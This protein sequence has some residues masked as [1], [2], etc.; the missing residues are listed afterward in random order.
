MFYEARII[1]YI[2]HKMPYQLKTLKIKNYI[3]TFLIN[4]DSNSLT[5]IKSI[6]QYKKKKCITITQRT[7]KK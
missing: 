2:I 7:S 6:N 3:Q 5:K 4:I 1:M